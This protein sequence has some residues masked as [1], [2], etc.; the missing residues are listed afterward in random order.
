MKTLTHALKATVLF[1]LAVE[2]AGCTGDY[3]GGGAMPSTS[4]IPGEKATFGFFVHLQN[5]GVSC[6][7]IVGASGQ[8]QFDDHGTGV[9]V[10]FHAV[11]TDW[12]CCW[13]DNNFDVHPLFSG[14]YYVKGKKVGHVLVG[15]QDYGPGSKLDHLLVAVL[16]GPF[17]GYHNGAD[18]EKGNV[19]Y[20][21]DPLCQ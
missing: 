10:S 14:D 5:D 18:F 19:T 13:V 11:I 21:P 1:L 2:L 8:F 20:N 16:D 7:N 6:N 9:N 17:A 4:G 15:A 12:A 3:S